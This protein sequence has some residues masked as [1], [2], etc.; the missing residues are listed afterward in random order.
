MFKCHDIY[1]YIYIREREKER[2]REREE[3]RKKEIVNKRW[4]K[5]N[6]RMN[7]QKML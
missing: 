1:I 5:Q 4:L 7:R 3:E 2:K 6:R